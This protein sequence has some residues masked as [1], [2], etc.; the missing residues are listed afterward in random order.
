M[1][2]IR[3]KH[4]P[5]YVIQRDIMKYL[6]QR[7]WWV[8]RM[9]GNMYQKGIPDLYITHLKFGQRWLDVKNPASWQ[10]TKAQCQKWPVWHSY[11]IGIWILVAAT[12]EEYDKLFKPPNWQDYWKPRYDDYLI[13]VDSLLA[14]LLHDE[15]EQLSEIVPLSTSNLKKKAKLIL[16]SQ[17]TD[18][19]WLD[20]MGKG[21]IEKE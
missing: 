9:H 16:P 8:E 13:S 1:K 20:E 14:E 3:P 5:E 11:G 18:L 17:K 10:Y 12:E 6:R 2:K 15:N 4:G 21:N 19:S 7:G